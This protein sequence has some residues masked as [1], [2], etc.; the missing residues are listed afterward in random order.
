MKG[1]KKV[2]D[3]I[4]APKYYYKRIIT[5]LK[6]YNKTAVNKKLSLRQQVK[7]L[8]KTIWKIGITG[9]GKFHFWKLMFWT[10]FR[11]PSLIPEA[12]TH[13]IYGYH[14]RTVLLTKRENKY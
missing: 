2:I 8:S 13:S 10:I 14:Y 4:F 5:Y 12:I 1:Y 11:K 6:E 3:T 7:A 9:K